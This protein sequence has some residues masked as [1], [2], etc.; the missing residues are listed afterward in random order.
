MIDKRRLW[1]TRGSRWLPCSNLFEL[2]SKL[3]R[4]EF[5]N[6]EHIL[7]NVGVND[8]DLSSAEEIHK[9]M[10]EIV[11]RLQI[12]HPSLKIILCEL[13]PRCDKRDTEV[14]K[15]NALLH[16]TYDNEENVFM[17]VHS[18]LRDP[19]HSLYRD[20]KHIHKDGIAKFASNLKNGLRAA[21]GISR[22]GRSNNEPLKDHNIDNRNYHENMYDNKRPVQPQFEKDSKKKQAK[23]LMEQF[24][25]LIDEVIG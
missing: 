1:T 16:K 22:W 6:L 23:H 4:E 21:Y 12:D 15:C 18:N 14:L 2:E 13:T 20:T 24:I 5:N 3:F 9:S 19:K 10:Q 17:V 7:I 25:R 11:T 8:S